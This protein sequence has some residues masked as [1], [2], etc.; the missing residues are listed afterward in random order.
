[1][2]KLKKN[3]KPFSCVLTKDAYDK[4]EQYCKETGRSKTIVI[5]RM[6]QKWCNLDNDDLFTSNVGQS[7]PG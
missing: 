4:L 3:G 1:M 6:I 7:P 2:G 5:E